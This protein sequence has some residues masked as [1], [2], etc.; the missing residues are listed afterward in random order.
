M[1]DSPYCTNTR[2][3][4]QSVNTKSIFNLSVTGSGL[5]I[6]FQVSMCSIT[7]DWSRK[8]Q[9]ADGCFNITLE[10]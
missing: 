8:Q 9:C 1:Q 3:K 5:Q 6:G 2:N 10:V 7:V 4:L